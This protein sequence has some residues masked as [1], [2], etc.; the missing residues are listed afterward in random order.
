MLEEFWASSI[1]GGSTGEE[2]RSILCGAAWISS[3]T[4]DIRPKNA[5]GPGIVRGPFERATKPSECL[6]LEAN[7][8]QTRIS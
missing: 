4:E 2:G 3:M 1:L 5:L 7:L 6:E 8:N